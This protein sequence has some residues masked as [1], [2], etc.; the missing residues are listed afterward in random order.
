LLGRHST[1]FSHSTSLLQFLFFSFFFFF[2]FL[3]FYL[4][5]TSH[6]NKATKT[7]HIYP[8]VLSALK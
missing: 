5:L 8:S 7:T 6:S 3:S 2:R 4:N 1:M